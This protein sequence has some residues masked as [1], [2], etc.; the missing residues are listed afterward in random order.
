[1]RCPD[2]FLLIVEL[3]L[4]LTALSVL[5]LSILDI[6]DHL[7]PYL[8]CKSM[9]RV[10]SLE[11]HFVLL[12]VGSRWLNQRSLHYLPILP[13]RLLAILDHLLGPWRVTSWIRRSSSGKVQGPFITSGFNTFC[14][15]CRH[16]TSVRF[17][18]CRDIFFQF[19][20]PKF[21]TIFINY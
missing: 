18:R 13:E 4:F 5:P 1:M 15:R 6:N 8:E 17:F 12:M 9:I 11:V 7:L 10:S 16:C 20:A 3:N 19:L 2:I 14:Q 21:K